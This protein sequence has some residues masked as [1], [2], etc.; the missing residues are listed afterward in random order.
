MIISLTINYLVILP[1]SIFNKNTE[2]YLVKNSLIYRAFFA[3]ISEF[4]NTDEE[5]KNIKDAKVKFTLIYFLVFLLLAILNMMFSTMFAYAPEGM[6]IPIILL[7]IFIYFVILKNINQ[8]AK[9]N[10][11]ASEI[12]GG[13]YKKKIEKTGGLYD[14]IVDNFNN[15]GSLKMQSSPKG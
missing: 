8:V 6:M 14:G 10:R 4:S 15:I 12:V 3:A 7:G 1:K 9:I 2:N 13:N 5:N 11:E